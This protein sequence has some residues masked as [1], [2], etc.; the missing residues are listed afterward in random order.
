MGDTT[1]QYLTP[2]EMAAIMGVHIGVI[3]RA[4][5]AG[6]MPAL[7]IGR[8]RSG[9]MHVRRAAFEQWLRHKEQQGTDAEEAQQ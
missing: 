3:R 8:G 7:R 5:A 6:E 2:R 4:I 9:A 1:R